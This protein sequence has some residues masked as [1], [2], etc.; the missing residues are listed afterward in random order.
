MSDKYISS[1]LEV[2]SPILKAAPHSRASE[3]FQPQLS[4]ET[5]VPQFHRRQSRFVQA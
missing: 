4:R 1:A 3:K 2:F 5:N